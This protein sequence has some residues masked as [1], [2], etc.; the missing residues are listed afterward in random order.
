MAGVVSAA[1]QENAAGD[2]SDGCILQIHLL[3]E[4]TISD[5]L[6][7]LGEIGV[8]RGQE[9]VAAKA[10]AIGLGR[11]S[12]PGQKMIVDR[13]IILSRLAS[14]GIPTAA[15]KLT[16]AESVT[17]KKL[18]AVIT[19]QD[20]VDIA[21]SFLKSNPPAG[22]VCAVEAI[23]PPKDLVLSESNQDIA[24]TPTYVKSEAS[25]QGKVRVAV[26]TGEKEVGVREITFRLKY[27]VR[28]IVSKSEI[29]AGAAIGP[30]NVRI[31]TAVCD[32]PDPVSWKPPYGQI[33]KRRLPADTVVM[34]DMLESVKPEVVVKRNETV[35]MR[36]ERSGLFVTAVGTAMQEA[37]SG[38]FIKVRNVDSQ[39]VV[40]CKVNGDGT[41]EPVM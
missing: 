27:Q 38:E 41:V 11:I 36:I 40:L 7:K 4:V 31:E 10:R 30:E 32:K 8:I 34:D 33:T 15:V 6:L 23:R 19:G 16:G 17:V 21:R 5:S 2:I 14:N 39:R 18:Q 20:F 13:T 35:V 1:S 26:I 28:R 9:S 29:P 3:R 22:S 12:M 25:D 24:I 37:R